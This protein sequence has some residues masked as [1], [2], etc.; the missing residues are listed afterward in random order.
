MKWL[1][2]TA[3]ACVVLAAPAGGAT[4]GSGRIVLVRNHLCQKGNDCGLGEI[5]VVNADG[6]GLRVL[7]HDKV[8]ELSPRWSPDGR[9]IA[10][11]R[12]GAQD[13]GQIW[14]MSA[15]GSHQRA[16]TRLR[17]VQLY[18]SSAMPSLDWSP[19]GRQIVFAAYP[20]DP[21]NNGGPQHLYF[22]SARTGAV[23]ALT[24]GSSM[25]TNDEAPAWSPDGRWIAFRR[26]PSRIML[27]STATDRVH[28]L[29]YRGASLDACCLAW[30]PDSRR[31]AFNKS[32]KIQVIDADGTHLRSLGVWGDDPSWSPDG[33]WIAFD[34]AA[35]NENLAE[36]RADGSG[37][38]LITRLGL[39]WLNIQPDWGR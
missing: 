2:L 4:S 3:L 33:E 34:S 35:K 23:T 38:H 8:T 32:G 28:E 11:I 27:L 12:P 5:V 37:F 14:L 17:S 30:S 26:A 6:S 24:K 1:L 29:K 10:Y 21:E 20:P 9:E 13:R 16:L 39:K 19:T 31:L 7:T 22:A 36:I 25:R 15:D 18:G